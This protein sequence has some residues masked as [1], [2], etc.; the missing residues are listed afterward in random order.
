MVVKMKKKINIVNR[1]DVE[2]KDAK[3]PNMDEYD[4]VYRCFNIL[5][6]DEQKSKADEIEK[7]TKI[8]K[9][10]RKK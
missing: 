6:L 5:S 9:N 1:L 4:F 8:K 7:I 2:R 10:D 3:N